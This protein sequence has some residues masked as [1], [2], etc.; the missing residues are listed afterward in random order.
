MITSIKLFMGFVLAILGLLAFFAGYTKYGYLLK[1]IFGSERVK[2]KG[3]K[4]LALYL[5][6]GAGVLMFLALLLLLP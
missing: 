6:I 5:Y 2:E 4:W 1:L 3:N